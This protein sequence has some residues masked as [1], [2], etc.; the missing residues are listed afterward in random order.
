MNSFIWISCNL[1]L[2][3]ILT[4]Y[5]KCDNLLKN[6]KITDTAHVGEHCPDADTIYPCTCY[7]DQDTNYINLNCS[8]VEGEDEL[9]QVFTSL[10]SMNF[11]VLIMKYNQH[12]KVLKNGVFGQV[13]FKLFSLTW[14][15]I[16]EIEPG[17]LDGSQ[18]TA[19]MMEFDTNYISIFPF[20]SI[21]NFTNLIYLSLGANNIT[22]F[23]I[24]RSQ[25]LTDLWLISNPMGNIP[26]DA[27]EHLPS[28]STIQLGYCNITS[29]EPGHFSNLPKLLDLDLQYNLLSHIPS[30]AIA[31]GSS[32]SY[33]IQLSNNKI[34]EVEP[35]A[36]EVVD[37]MPLFLENNQLSL[38]KEE[39]WRP[40]LEAKVF[41]ALYGNPLECGC[42]LAWIIYEPELLEQITYDTMC[43]DGRF[44][45]DL[46]PDLFVD[47]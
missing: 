41:L 38:L 42:D 9:A 16:E 37:E 6:S 18:D 23:P 40:L 4:E 39:V 8:S 47:C 3:F 32:K 17:V 2:I 44:I 25:S 19:L 13:T 7:V 26:A 22:A 28:L 10:P 11:D 35:D 14:G 21:D 43:A 36:I 33:D 15:V 27:F 29:I 24:L 20:E 12:V 1:I 30:G 45:H 46:D 34:V 31:T 5:I